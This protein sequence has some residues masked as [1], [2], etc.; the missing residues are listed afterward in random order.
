MTDQPDPTFASSHHDRGVLYAG[1]TEL[2]VMHQYYEPSM[3]VMNAQ[4]VV[5]V[6]HD[7][8]FSDSVVHA[9]TLTSISNPVWRKGSPRSGYDALRRV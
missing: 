8:R 6:S 1:Y 3:N 7:R 9:E 4:T 2:H 5:W